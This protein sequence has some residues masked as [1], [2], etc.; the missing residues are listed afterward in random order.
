MSAGLTVYFPKIG[1]AGQ[2]LVDEAVYGPRLQSS[3]DMVCATVCSPAATAL[4]ARTSLK[5]SLLDTISQR[6]EQPFKNAV[7]GAK[8]SLEIRYGLSRA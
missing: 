5:L 3:A 2:Q 4:S 1:A 8:P 7:A 6:G